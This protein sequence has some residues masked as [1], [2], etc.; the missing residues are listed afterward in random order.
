MA[1]LSLIYTVWT[2]WLL[3]VPL[4]VQAIWNPIISGWNPDGSILR[5]GDDYYI[6]T[7]SFEY[8]PGIPIYHSK[9]L[10]DWKLKS[11]ALTR[12]EQ[13]QLYGT[14]TGAGAWA[15]SLAFFDGKFWLS[16]MTRWTY[17]PVARVWPRVWFMSSPDLKTWSNPVWAEPWGIDPELFHD[18]LTNTTY[19]NLM[20]PN[21]NKDRLWGLYQC[22]VSLKTGDCVARPEGPKMYYKDDW[23]YL[24]TAEGGTDQLHRASIAR[25]KSPSGPFQANPHNPL[26]YNGKWGFTNLT[27][28]STGHATLVETAKGEWYASFLARRNI[29]GSSPLGR[30]TFL[31][32]VDWKDGWPVLNKGNPILLS[33]QVEPKSGPKK[34][35]SRW[36]D[37]FSNHKLDPSWYQ[38]RTPYT[39]NYEL[40]A[41]RL[42]L[43]PNVFSLSER[44]SPAA[45]LRKQKSLNMTW[46]AELSSFKGN[47]GPRNRLGISSYLSEFQHQDIGISGCVN[48]T[49]I[50]IYTE[51]NKNGTQEASRPPLSRI[52]VSN[53]LQYWQKPLKQAKGLSKELK[54]HIRAEP[55]RYRLGYSF[56]SD[57]PTY[58]TSIASKWQAFAP[59]NWFVFSGASF[60]LFATGGGEPWPGNGPEVGF[61]RVWENYH[62]EDIPDYDRW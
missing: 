8:W 13:L 11:H 44:D 49:G 52:T 55:L 56:G 20:A 18:P 19:L 17:D 50:C 57:Q 6:A 22:E 1:A 48:Q 37:N 46:S 29:N 21:N 26:M 30:E 47:L 38:L 5:V 2:F 60:A 41:G 51:L 61:E 12:P 59:P 43:K 31:V 36:I 27:V 10:S 14:P 33:E 3:L 54:L 28:Q 45:R 25:S 4:P 9:D 7:S 53:Y 24:L 16:A 15:P 35:P 42:V 62:E 39:K 34:T 23:Y 32:N 58:V 40:K